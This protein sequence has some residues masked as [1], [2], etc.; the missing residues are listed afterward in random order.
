MR[1]PI[2]Y[3]SCL[4][5]LITTSIPWAQQAP[6]LVAPTEALS[7]A[8]EMKGFKLPK[9]YVV[10]LV[11][12]EPDIFK[13]MNLSFDYKGRIWIT[14]SLEYPYAAKDG[15]KPRDSVKI[16]S[17]IGPDGK[18]QK[19]ETFA[20][21][22]NIPIGLLPLPSKKGAPQT[23]LVHSIPNVYKMQDTN[24]DNKADTKEPFLTGFGF[25]DTHGM[26]NSFQLHW[27]GW[28][29][30]THGFSND[31]EVKSSE[32]KLL[33]MNSGNTY[34]YRP[35]GTGLQ[36]YTRGQ[37]NPF[38]MTVD[39]WGNFYTAD[40]HSSPIYQLIQ[41]ATYPSFSKPHDGLGFGPIL[42]STGLNHKS[43]LVMKSGSSTALGVAPFRSTRS[44]LILLVTTLPMIMVS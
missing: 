36:S 2:I 25:R 9:G 23:A 26:T 19:I 13:P 44:W 21:G 10:Q 8:D 29:H 11:A 42:I 6:P 3:S 20:E 1:K 7:P 32:G 16:L 39:S 28:V 40:C 24:N 4:V 18:A 30:A 31:S 41:G 17:N 38:G 12:S 5:F 22:L 43:S 27:D 14:D 15:T 33:K 34:R 35:D 37:V